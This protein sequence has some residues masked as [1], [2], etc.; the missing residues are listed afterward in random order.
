MRKVL[1][2]AVVAVGLAGG[3]MIAPRLAR[4]QISMVTGSVRGQLV[5]KTDGAPAAGAMV[6]ATST[7]LQGEQSTFTDG[8][9]L[10]FLTA[11]PAG[12]YTLTVHY[13]NGTFTRDNVLIQ[14]GKEA[15]VNIPVD[16]HTAQGEVITIAGTVPLVDQGSTK[17]GLSITRDYTDNVPVGR[18]FG[19]VIGVAATAQ[20]DFYGTSLS[21]ATSIENT[22]IIEGVN[23]TDTAHGELSLTLPNEF[24]AE[25]E[26]ITGGYNAEYGR[27]TGGIVN[28]VTKQGANEIHGSVFS[29]FSPGALSPAART[30]EKQG[31]SV[32][33]QQHLDY[34][35]D[36][37][38]EVGGAIIPDKLWFHVGFDP[39][40]TRNLVTRSIVQQVDDDQDGVPDFDPK[41]GLTLHRKVA[42]RD[43]P[44]SSTTYFFTA[45]LTG[46]INPDHQFQLSAFGNPQTGTQPIYDLPYAETWGAHNNVL[47]RKDGAFDTVA[48]YTGKLFD[49]ATQIDATAGFHRSYNHQSAPGGSAGAL[50]LA[51]YNYTRSLYD[52]ADVEGS[53]IGACQDG[54]P[55]DKYPLIQ[56][57]P[58]DLYASQGLALLEQ[59]TNDRL[60]AAL[61]VTQR[62]KLL[63]YHVFKAGLDVERASYNTTL[64]FSGGEELQRHCNVDDSGNCVDAPDGAPGS[65]RVLGYGKIVRY[66]T[67]AEL[68]NPGS[69]ALGPHQQIDGCAGGTAICTLADARHV[70]TS[71]RS[72]GAYLQDSWQIVPSLT[73]DVGVRLEQQVLYNAD[74]IQGTAD[75]TGEPIP[76]VAFSLDNWAPR[77]GLIF[78]P[79]QS[80]KAKL[81]A[82]WGRFYENLPNDI[83]VRAFGGEIVSVSNTNSHQLRP[84]Q[85]GY[86]P[87]CNVDHQAGQN[88]ATPLASCSDSDPSA[89]LL[90][91]GTTYVPPNIS[92]QYT[93][94][95]VV[96]GELEIMPDLK[97]S[98][99]YT[100]RTMP[101]IIED[102][103][104]DGGAS[105]LIAN[106]GE[107]YDAEADKLLA[108]A[109]RVAAS[110][111]TLAAT[112]QQRASWLTSVKSFDAP[113][114]N[115]DAAT[116]RLEQRPTHRSLLIASYT[117]AR[118]RGNYPGLF[119]TETNQLDPNATTMYDLPDLMANRYGPLG[120]DRPHNFKLDGF[121]LFDL[122]KAGRLTVGASFRAQSGIAH[123]VL[124]SHPVYGV[125]ESYLL[126]RGSIDRSPVTNTFDL[127]VGYG[128]QLS[129]KVVLEAFVNVFN[130]FDTQDELNVDEN[131]T[132]DNALPIVGGD[133]NDLKHAKAIQYTP[134]GAWATVNR[135]LIPNLNYDH[136][137][138]VTNPRAFQFGVRLSF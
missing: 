29:Y 4:A 17:I 63:G 82:H 68:A 125:G 104:P 79:S 58:V 19:Q 11:L 95:L 105:F 14:V 110:N 64:Q 115:Y 18:T 12:Y 3:P 40:Y 43:I 10:Y 75:G 28:V 117:Y 97:V 13:L 66:L 54:G 59:R 122:A 30:I 47:D 48:K 126:P 123:N 36:V 127:H 38:A 65:W 1:S 130:L 25:T 98:A 71:D 16:S 76:D 50:A 84:G 118:E 37:G 91:S 23:T 44:T 136:T 27:A 88:P 133:A 42:S 21:G 15:V 41:T 24:L 80:G 120:L 87:N 92:G 138:Q 113:V 52:F 32:A 7:A 2:Y 56:N 31:G 101:R 62:V 93:D 131:Y 94:E 8:D 86:D 73:L 49:G 128:H 114:R 111:P 81:F 35:Y 112:L 5:D 100:H 89:L 90:G 69:V 20:R 51:E 57:C 107:N 72:I 67:P 121:Y 129:D 102:L 60:T 124:A 70:K 119:S 132:F 22:Y 83:N 77:L 116:L 55:G 109:G 45:K 106:P 78:D 85:P 99:S 134:S 135:T 39:S 46:Q 33:I 74:G 34:S 6:T 137:S 9:G 53:G 103:S 61:S 26:I 96:G 108:Q